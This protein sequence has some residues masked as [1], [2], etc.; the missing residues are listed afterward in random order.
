MDVYTK[1]I[2][3]Q[4]HRTHFTMK[5][6]Y[7]IKSISQL[8]E[9]C[10]GGKAKHPLI[11][12]LDL[13]KINVSK[14]V[15]EVKISTDFYGVT[16]KTKAPNF[17]K[18][19][20][21]YIDFEE[22]CLYGSAPKQILEIP[23]GSET[24]NF[25]GCALYFH[26]DLIRGTELTNKISS[27]G[28]FDYKTNEALHLSDDE[29]S[30]LFSIIERIKEEY[31]TNID[32]FSQNVLVSNIELLLS[33]IERYFSRQFITRKSQ[34]SDLLSNF[35]QLIKEYF[36]SDMIHEKGL[37]TV[38]YFST[39]LHLSSSYLSDL[40]KK[41]T[42]QNTQELIHYHLIEKAKDLLHN[43]KISVSEVAYQLGF[44]HPPYFSRLFKKKTKMSPSEYRSLL[45]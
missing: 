17:L 20:R 43:S 3:G 26:P 29:K 42:N 16:L 22:G 7:N 32:A 8:L 27:Y 34:N 21:S 41:E 15:S 39:K 45:N 18:Y 9:S 35:E 23:S 11:T 12:V 28:F 2:L 38:Q 36:N 31:E 13:A 14:T 6:T 5:N 40:L 25:E 24:G 1:K 4:N 10:N 33:Y 30:T 37:P 19:G 44:E